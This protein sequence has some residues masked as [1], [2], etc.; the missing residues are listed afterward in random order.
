MR[1]RFRSACEIEERAKI[2]GNAR[3]A[4]GEAR[5]QVVGRDVDLSLFPEKS[6]TS[7]LSTPSRLKMRPRS[8]VNEIFVAWKALYAYFSA[9]A[10]LGCTTRTGESRK[11]KRCE[12]TLMARTSEAPITVYG[13]E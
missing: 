12:S 2:S 8:L 13:G 3:S 11:E 5:S 7:R 6:M 10:V 4:E 1:R 9:S